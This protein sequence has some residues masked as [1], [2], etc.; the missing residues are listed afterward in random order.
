MSKFKVILIDDE[1][2]ARDELKRH[3]EGYPDFEIIG[4]A[5][6][7]DEAEA[8]VKM[9]QPDFIFLDIQMPGRTGFELLESLNDVPDVIFTTAF[10][11]YAVQAFEIN[12][13][14]YLVKPIREERFAKAMMHIRTRSPQNEKNKKILSANHTL[15]VKEGERL[16]FIKVKEIR[17]IESEGNYAKL[18]FGDKKVLIKRS[19]NQLETILDAILFFRINRTTI[20][21]TNYIKEIKSQQKGKL[22]IQLQTGELLTASIRQSAAFRNRNIY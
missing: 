10:D 13:I 5:A 18:S 12:A 6:N 8:M 3:L 11:K 4:E 21:N 17:L 15:F 22:S 9:L 1:R 20:I 19:L 7:A 14:D 2:L 16:H